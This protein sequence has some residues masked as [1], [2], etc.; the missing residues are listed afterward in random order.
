MRTAAIIVA[1]LLTALLGTALRH[2]DPAFIGAGVAVLVA[3][4]YYVGYLDGAAQR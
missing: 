1:V 2:D 3:L 4:G